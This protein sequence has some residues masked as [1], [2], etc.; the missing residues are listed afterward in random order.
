M[1]NDSN[2]GLLSLLLDVRRATKGGAPAIAQRQ[3]IRLAEI[4]RFARTHSPYYR[5]LYKDVP[6]SV[7]G[8]TVLPPTDKKT[9]MA[10][11]DE[12]ATDRDVTLDEASTFAANPD[13]IG[14]RFRGR[15][16]LATTSGTTGTPG[17]FIIDD[18]AMRVTSAIML[19]LLRSW[20]RFGDVSEIVASGRRLAMVADLGHHSATSVAAARL[21]KSPARR[22][23]VELLSVRA[24]L[25]RLVA[26]L[27]EFQP[28]LLAPYASMARLLASEQEAGR[29]TIRPVLTV[30]AAEGLPI[31]EYDRIAKAFGTKLGNSYAATE[32]PFLSYS[33][34]HHWLHV[35]ADWVLLE[36]VDA[37]H[38]PVRP[39]NQSHTVLITNLANRVQ[40]ILRYDLGDSVVQR[41]D[42]CPCGNP[43]PAIRVRGRSADVLT[44]DT[45]AGDA[46]AIA[47]LAFE[48]DHVNGVDLFQIVQTSPTS[49]AVRLRIKAADTEPVWRT[50][51]QEIRRMLD[52]HRL[53]NVRV[54]RGH[55]EPTQSAGGKYRS[56]IPLSQL[57]PAQHSEGTS[58]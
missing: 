3:R 55:Q 47:P 22:K 14:E 45:E 48:V 52:E 34:E 21:M 9:L 58:R 24:P 5:D 31:H 20:L 7:E 23:R 28:A 40:P 41:P 13:L 29:L 35:N 44:F 2:E 30:L 16:T 43:L 32:C 42:P 8:A 12:W 50:V 11:F 39:G 36:P 46:V 27:N 49:L 51:E 4:T 18:G 17:I 54:E 15:Y 19:R 26:Q 10:R 25:S 37:D 33:C 56:V 6:D 53:A 38:Q 1:R 57:S